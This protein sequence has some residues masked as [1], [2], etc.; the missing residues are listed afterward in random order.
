MVGW[1]VRLQNTEI[2]HD[3]FQED[4]QVAI[5]LCGEIFHA[6]CLYTWYETVKPHLRCPKCNGRA[7]VLAKVLFRM[8][9]ILCCD[10]SEISAR[11][12]VLNC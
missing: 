1:S 8:L 11:L 7:D 2:C 10:F 3:V 4:K 6:S 5:M 9:Y 12:S